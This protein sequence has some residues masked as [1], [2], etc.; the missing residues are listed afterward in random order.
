MLQEAIIASRLMKAGEQH[1][2][3]ADAVIAQAIV[4]IPTALIQGCTTPRCT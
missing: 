2:W 4:D 3:H 1:E